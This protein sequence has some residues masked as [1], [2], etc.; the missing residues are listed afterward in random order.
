MLWLFLN[1]NKRHTIYSHENFIIKTDLWNIPLILKLCFP[2]KMEES[3][4][5]SF[6][7]LFH[8]IPKTIF[9]PCNLTT[10][11]NLTLPI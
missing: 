3:P 9:N 11:D 2:S 4:P 1:P 6:F 10:D 5:F 7:S 8:L